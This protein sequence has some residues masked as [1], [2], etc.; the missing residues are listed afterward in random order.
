L[1]SAAARNGIAGAAVG[2]RTLG[3]ALFLAYPVTVHFARP[4]IAVALLTTLLAYIVA[5]LLLPVAARWLV[6]VVAAASAFFLGLPDA[7]WLLYLPPIAI[8]VVLS[9]LFGRTLMRGRTPLIAR[10]ALMEQGTLTEELAVY[11]RRLTWIWALL[12]AGAAATSL[13]LALSGSRDA[14][15]IF[16]NLANYLLVVALFLG[17]LVYRRL[18]FRNYRHQSP[19][20]LLRNVRRTSLFER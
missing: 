16:T 18:R 7:Q 8:N 19:L 11:T 1:R 13:F 2:W 10:F 12:F 15:S 3:V 20:Q 9:W 4:A 6:V 17:E 5:S 14:W